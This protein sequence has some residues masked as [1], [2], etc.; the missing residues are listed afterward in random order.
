MVRARTRTHWHKENMLLGSIAVLLGLIC[1]LV[2]PAAPPTISGRHVNVLLGSS[3]RN[4]Y[5]PTIVFDREFQ[6]ILTVTDN[7]DEAL[8][9]V[10]YTPTVFACD[11]TLTSCTKHV[12]EQIDL[13]GYYPSATIDEAGRRLLIVAQDYRRFAGALERQN[14]LRFYDCDLT[15]LSAPCAIQDLSNATR[16]PVGSGQFPLLQFDAVHRLIFIVHL[17]KQADALLTRCDAHATACVTIL[18]MRGTGNVPA[19]YSSVPPFDLKLDTAFDTVFIVLEHTPWRKIVMCT[20]SLATPAAPELLGCYNVSTQPGSKLAYDLPRMSFVPALRSGSSVPPSDSTDRTIVATRNS[21]MGAYPYELLLCAQSF[22]DMFAVLI[23]CREFPLVDS[24]VVQD[25]SSE[26]IFRALVPFVD[27]ANSLFLAFFSTRSD[28]WVAACDLYDTSRGCPLSSAGASGVGEPVVE[29]DG[30][31]LGGDTFILAGARTGSWSLVLMVAAYC[32]AVPTGVQLVPAFGYAQAGAFSSVDVLRYTQAGALSACYE[33]AINFVPLDYSFSAQQEPYRFDALKFSQ[34]WVEMGRLAGVNCTVQALVG[35]Y[36]LGMVVRTTRVGPASAR[37][38][39]LTS[40]MPGEI[41]K[42]STVRLT[43][44]LSDRFGNVLV[45]QAKENVSAR[46]TIGAQVFALPVAAVPLVGVTILL[47]PPITGLVIVEITINGNTMDSLASLAVLFCPPGSFAPSRT[48]SECLPCG[49]DTYTDEPN[50]IVC[51]ACPDGTSTQSRTGATSVYFCT[52]ELGFVLRLPSDPA[53][54]RCRPCPTGAVCPGGNAS[55]LA[56]P[57]YVSVGDGAS[58]APCPWP[59]ACPGGLQRCARGY[60][61]EYCEGC[62]RHFYRVGLR[63]HACSQL[64]SIL[65]ALALVVVLLLLCGAILLCSTGTVLAGPGQ[66]GS[67]SI[68]V[69]TLQVVALFATIDVSWPREIEAVFSV[70]D[71]FSLKLELSAPECASS[72]VSPFVL[73]LVLT[74]LLPVLGAIGMVVATAPVCCYVLFVRHTG[75]RFRQTQAH[76]FDESCAVR[77]VDRETGARIAWCRRRWA[78]LRGTVSHTPR[79]LCMAAMRGY[80]QLLVLLFLPLCLA[81]LR[82][83]DCK[84]VGPGVYVVAHAPQVK[85]FS[86]LW[87]RLAP[88]VALFALLYCVGIP[89]LFVVCLRRAA[90]RLSAVEFSLRYGFLTGRYIPSQY[91]SEVVLL[92]RTLSIVLIVVVCTTAEVEAALSL[93][94]LLGQAYYSR[95][96]EPYNERRHNRMADGSIA[97]AVGILLGVLVTGEPLRSVIVWLSFAGLLGVCLVGLAYDVLCLLRAD[98]RV[99]VTFETATAQTS[100]ASAHSEVDSPTTGRRTT[101]AE[102]AVL[103][104]ASGAPGQA[105]TLG[106][107]GVQMV[108][109]S[110]ASPHASQARAAPVPPPAVDPTALASALASWNFSS[111]LPTSAPALPVVPQRASPP[112]ALGSVGAAAL[113]SSSSSRPV[114]PARPSAI[115]PVLPPGARAHSPALDSYLPNLA[116]RA[117]PPPADES[118]FATVEFDAAELDSL[119]RP[120]GT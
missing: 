65:I 120:T 92:G 11:L 98:R 14:T 66:L 6:R 48:D 111:E 33:G 78:S 77:R 82:F 47:K 116:P 21:S 99:H 39:A 74:L 42:N 114:V 31:F 26:R 64:R 36:S 27:T 115:R 55:A 119:P 59:H 44:T 46:M 13:T 2:A 89:L 79:S 60:A 18:L 63:C 96:Y 94:V 109:L 69:T 105:S 85:C 101:V 86:A 29:I 68:V 15:N 24:C 7:G 83:F 57:G 103:T 88:V 71:V 84:R 37:S 23:A 95:A 90:R 58:F 22:L 87:N 52:C 38:S 54:S 110:A 91:L 51:T 1:A 20:T 5:E 30:V 56:L 34:A 25:L 61:G 9:G 45:D 12:L 73:V 76:L 80:V 8:D 3:G 4:G 17:N 50:A 81:T 118:A 19:D 28:V 49:R 106:D 53:G 97:G 100:N 16:Q 75:A 104:Y 43:L 40:S 67:I 108:M 62:A 70:A 107:S 10:L 113:A 102:A 93:L 117:P 112:G 41:V 32:P 35:N 72:V